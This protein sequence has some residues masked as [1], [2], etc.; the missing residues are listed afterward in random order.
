MV[1]GPANIIHGQRKNFVL[2]RVLMR[3]YGLAPK[4]CYSLLLLLKHKIFSSIFA[5][6]LKNLFFKDQKKLSIT[7]VMVII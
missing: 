4:Q 3:P 7:K 5:Q 2:N 6:N 1:K